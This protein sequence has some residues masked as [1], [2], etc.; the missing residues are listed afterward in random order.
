MFQGSLPEKAIKVIGNVVK[1]WDCE[2]IV[3]GCSGNFTIERALSKFDNV[4]KIVSNDVT[5]YSGY[6]GKYFVGESLDEL[7]VR[8]DYEGKCGWFREYMKTPTEKIATL[9]MASD[10]LKYD[11]NG[12]A[13]FDRMIGAYHE[14]WPVLHKKM[15][16]KL[17]SLQLKIREFY[18]GDVMKLLDKLDEDC[19]FISFP[20]FFKGGYEKMWKDLENTFTYTPPDYEEFDPEKHIELFCRK[21]KKAKNFIIGAEREVKELEGY[22][23]GIVETKK[24]KPIYFYSKTERKV[25]VKSSNDKKNDLKI[26]RIAKEDDIDS[27]ELKEVPHE[28]FDELRA[29]YLSKN[30]KKLA[31]ESA[32]YGLFT[33]GKL[34][35]VF[36]FSSSMT[37]VNSFGNM[38]D[39]PT[40]YLMTDFAVSPTKYKHLSKLVLMCA[41]SKESKLLAEKLMGKRVRSVCTNAFSNN[42]VSMKYRGIFEQFGRKVTEKDEEGKPKKYNLTYGAKMGEW[43]LEEAFEKWKRKYSK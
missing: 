12:I 5:I 2:T 17:E 16:D 38:I 37:L 23:V 18:F 21:A 8:E 27:V 3:V 40:I 20:P 35:G 13:Y 26:E 31:R 6:L 34:F 1:E 7:E 22:F 41:L 32:A 28:Q 24:G 36:A 30:V 19:G 39:G 29:V 42:P 9:I 14:Q 10:V 43:T 33:K 11:K 25:F 15:C 4:K